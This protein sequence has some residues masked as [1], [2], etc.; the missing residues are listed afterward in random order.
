MKKILLTSLL[1]LCASLTYAGSSCGGGGCDS[2]KKDGKEDSTQSNA[3]LAGGCG[4]C[5][6]TIKIKRIKR[7]KLT[8]LKIKQS[9]PAVAATRKIKK[10]ARPTLQT[11][12]QPLPDQA[13]ATNVATKKTA[14]PTLLCDR[15]LL[16]SSRKTYHQ[17]P[18]G[19]AFV[20]LFYAYLTHHRCHIDSH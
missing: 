1:M 13:V 19:P 18:Y 8:S 7:Q 4:G 12:L 16:S 14:S 5:G 11:Q 2:D 9:W 20:R 10:T 6:A 17:K 15:L 3:V